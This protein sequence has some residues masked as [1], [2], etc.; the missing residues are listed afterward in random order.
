MEQ[1][2]CLLLLLPMPWLFAI[3]SP[4]AASS[5]PDA[6]PWQQLHLGAA[7]GHDITEQH[8]VTPGGTKHEG[9]G[10]P[11]ESVCLQ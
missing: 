9:V 4:D 2:A 5:E 8:M 11:V 3:A 7:V 1:G 10:V 6:S